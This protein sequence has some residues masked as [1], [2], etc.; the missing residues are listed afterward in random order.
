[1]DRLRLRQ[2][3]RGQSRAQI[4][5][6]GV[7]RVGFTYLYVA[8]GAGHETSWPSWNRLRASV[9]RLRRFYRVFMP[10]CNQLRWFHACWIP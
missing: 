4:V 1:M 6:V 10:A 7:S 8:G 3:R 9:N 2:S 5:E